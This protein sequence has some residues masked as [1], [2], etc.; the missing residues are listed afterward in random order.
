MIR[1]I[2]RQNPF[3]KLLFDPLLP[4]LLPIFFRFFH[5]HITHPNFGPINIVFTSLL[6]MHKLQSQ[7]IGLLLLNCTT[8]PLFCLTIVYI[9]L[10][11]YTVLQFS[12]FLLGFFT[13]Y[14]KVMGNFQII[15]WNLFTWIIFYDPT[16]FLILL[17]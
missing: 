2:F 10:V 9:S 17:Q 1:P 12:Q 13:L 5:F 8:R 6:L 11:Q 3:L 14:S 15:L 16:R 4:C 7:S